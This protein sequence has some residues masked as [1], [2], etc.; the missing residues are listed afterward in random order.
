M[1]LIKKE[2]IASLKKTQ[3]KTLLLF[4][5]VSTTYTIP[6]LAYLYV[7]NYLEMTS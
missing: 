7:K 6:A 2:Y 3:E 5:I 4:L 1:G